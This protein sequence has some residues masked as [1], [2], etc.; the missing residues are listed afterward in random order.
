[1]NKIAS[2]H[3]RFQPFHNGHLAYVR[4]ALEQAEHVYVGLTRVLTEPG[5]GKDVAPHR[6]ELKANPFTYFE[7]CQLV[8]AALEGAGVDPRRWTIGP[9]P[10]E[11]P[12]RLPEFWPLAFPC[13]TTVVDT[14]N[15]EKIRVLREIGY[16]VEVLGV[17]SGQNI[18]SGT[19]VRADL[20]SGGSSWK[21]WTPQGTWPILEKWSSAG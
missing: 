14:W 10:I 17:A 15:D 16:V 13:M 4:E 8:N 2:V 7:R 20:R 12:T 3:G 11:V 1:M 6:L 5:I 18:R 9:F 19:Q 21:D